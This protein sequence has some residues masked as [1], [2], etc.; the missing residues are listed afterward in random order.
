MILRIFNLK[1]QVKGVVG[2]T[3]FIAICE[4]ERVCSTIACLLPSSQQI[5]LFHI[6][7]WIPSEDILSNL[8]AF[9]AKNP[10]QTCK[11]PFVFR[12]LHLGIRPTNS[13]TDVD[14]IPGAQSSTSSKDFSTSLSF[15]LYS[16]TLETVK[17]VKIYSVFL[18]VYIR[19]YFRIRHSPL[20][21][22]IIIKKTKMTATTNNFHIHK[23]NY[24]HFSRLSSD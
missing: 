20:C 10:A 2:K 11:W 1:S 23:L 22:K 16:L 12:W 3:P 5:F 9:Q 18:L 8:A 6:K 19:Q 7:A 15:P 17:L 14:V 24:E 13:G 21:T 4:K